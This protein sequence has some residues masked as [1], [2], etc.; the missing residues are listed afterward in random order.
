[1][2]LYEE[3]QYDEDG[4]PLTGTFMDYLLPTAAEI[5]TLR[6][7]HEVT[8]STVVPTGVKGIGEAGT[9]GSPS[10]VAAAVEDALRPF[11]AEIAE[12]PLTPEKVACWASQVSPVGTAR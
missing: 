11:G 7:A 5:P 3:L 6:L 9:I 8:P 2:S 1:M 12:L 10:A 4:Y